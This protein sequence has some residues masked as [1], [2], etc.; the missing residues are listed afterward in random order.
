M[1]IAFNHQLI[2]HNKIIRE[3]TV[4]RY[5]YYWYYAPKWQCVL[6][7][8]LLNLQHVKRKFYRR[9]YA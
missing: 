3:E 2:V 5:T 7:L 6:L 9:Q 4:G 8:I 1:L